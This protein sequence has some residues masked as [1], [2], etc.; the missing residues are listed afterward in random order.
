MRDL[1]S[2]A[3]LVALSGACGA[4]ERDEVLLPQTGAPVVRFGRLER[5]DPR[6]TVLKGSYCKVYPVK[7]A[8]GAICQIDMESSM[9]DSYLRLQD[10]T[11]K[12]VASDDD[13]GI[14]RNAR[15]RYLPAQGGVF[16]IVATT[17]HVERVGT[18]TL[19]VS[20]NSGPV[21]GAKPAGAIAL[22][23]VGGR[24]ISTGTL[25]TGDP[26]DKEQRRSY[27]HVCTAELIE[28]NNYQ[29]DLTSKTFDAYLR[30][31]D[32]EGLPLSKNNGGGG[33]LD[34]RITYRC[35]RSGTYRVIVTTM[36]AAATGRYTLTVQQTA[37]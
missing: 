3:L 22:N 12:Q 8:A 37:K 30:L 7:L 29:I 13:G 4:Q 5:T 34:A 11:G 10:A 2:L 14:G 20:Q 1:A 15:I 26:K 25:K 17:Y 24:A 19:K 28:G 32:P 9:L 36:R 23:L 21:I 33:N 35:L 16:L 27:C 31:E 6:D 18:F